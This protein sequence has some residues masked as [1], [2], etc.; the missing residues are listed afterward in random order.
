[1]QPDLSLWLPPGKAAHILGVSTVRVRQLADRGDLQAL[2]TPMGRL[3]DPGEV[4][5]LRCRRATVTSVLSSD[6]A[7][8]CDSRGRIAEHRPQ[9]DAPPDLVAGR[10]C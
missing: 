9:L 6:G 1:M 8:E 3:F 7:E 2:R 10:G 4:E 5:R